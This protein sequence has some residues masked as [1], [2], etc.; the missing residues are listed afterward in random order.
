[1]S[2]KLS[3]RPSLSWLFA[4]I[5]VTLALEHLEVSAPLLFFSAALAIVP[6]ASLI[7]HSTEQLAKRTGDAIGG[8]LNATFGNAPELIIAIVS[9]QAG[10][11]EMTLASL[12]GAILANL[13]F[14]LGAAFFLGGLRKHEQHFNARST[15]L[16]TSMMLIAVI[17]LIVPSAFS[18]FFSS[19]A[20]NA[21]AERSL[22]LILG[23]LLLAA[24]GLYLLFM[25]K[26]HADLFR[27]EGGAGGKKE[28][29][30]E[31]GPGWSVARAVASLVA[32]SV[33]AAW[34]S[35]ILVGAAEG[36]GKALGMSQTFIGM[37]FLALVG[38]AAESGSAIAM[39]RKDK[40]DL[41]VGIALGSSVQI[42][43]FVAPLLIFAS[44]FV[45]PH[46]IALSFNRAET[47]SLLLA[48]LIG[49]TVSNDGTSNWYK[50][51]QLLTVYAVLATLF[52][53][54]PT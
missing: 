44:Y 13:L 12:V 30:E 23:V 33:L 4:F 34:M 39:G 24:Y 18:R 8:L 47:G 14:A 38:G 45:G 41:A 53:F 11:Y 17:S 43:L 27:S 52:Y 28:E 40:M 48:V 20:E 1:M 46:P 7:V 37:V 9:L 15:R 31:H 25:I 26:T 5:P 3:L 36:T 22:N 19:Q 51:V 16:Y 10:L 21:G 2:M 35:E 54:I 49:T 29:E 42:A 6:I 50:G 32:A